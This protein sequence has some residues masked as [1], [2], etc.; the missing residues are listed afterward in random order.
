[1]IIGALVLD[2]FNHTNVTQVY[3]WDNYRQAVKLKSKYKKLLSLSLGEQ[4]FE[5]LK[6]LNEDS[7]KKQTENLLQKIQSYIKSK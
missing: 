3:T 2:Q 5:V 4:L 6:I 1:M 7:M